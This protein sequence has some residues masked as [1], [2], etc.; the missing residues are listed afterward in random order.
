MHRSEAVLRAGGR[1]PPSAS[2][3]RPRSPQLPPL[4]R[5]RRRCCA[6]RSRPGRRGFDP[7]RVCDA[8]SATV[9][10]AI[11]ERLLTYDYLARP[12][13]LVPMAAEGDAR[14]HRERPDL[15]VQHPQGHAFHARPRVQ[16]RA[17]RADR[18][19]FRLLVLRFVDPKNRSPYA[20]LVEGKIEGLDALAAKGEEVRQASTT[21]PR[22][23]GSTAVDRYTLR[24]RLCRRTTTIFPSSRPWCRRA[25]S[26]ARWSRPTATT[27]GASRWARDRTC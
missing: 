1:S 4:R 24:F 3:R 13:K 8:N 23:R 22:C 12:A 15:H 7:V 10:E 21:T 20:F 5:I 2:P 18:A 9:I 16:G 27:S 17:A 25:P 14:S 26:R 11:F 6:S 19:G